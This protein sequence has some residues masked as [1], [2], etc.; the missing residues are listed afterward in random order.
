[1]TSKT[2]ILKAQQWL[3]KQMGLF[4]KDPTFSQ[5]AVADVG[6]HDW[7]ITEFG[8]WENAV[9]SDQ[10][11]AL[12]RQEKDDQTI[13]HAFLGLRYQALAMSLRTPSGRIPFDFE[14]MEQVKDLAKYPYSSVAPALDALAELTD[15]MWLSPKYLLEQAEQAAAPT[16]TLLEPLP[17]EIRVNPY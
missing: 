11:S 10:L 4:P 2:L 14:D 9:L 13:N 12:L 15:M 16:E 1:M 6:F 17:E 8:G 3:E 7:F 5:K